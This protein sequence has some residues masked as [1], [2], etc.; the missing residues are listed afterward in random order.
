MNTSWDQRDDEERRR[1][2][3]AFSALHAEDAWLDST[4]G[5]AERASAVPFTML[6]NAALD[7][8]TR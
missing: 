6:A 1:M 5:A 7:P 4:G 2:A 8:D 3:D